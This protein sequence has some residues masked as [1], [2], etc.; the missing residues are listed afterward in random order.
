MVVVVADRADNPIAQGS[1]VA[2][3][4]GRL[5]TNCHVVESA[6]LIT[7]FALGETMRA[8]VVSRDD[9]ADRCVLAVERSVTHSATIRNFD[10][11]KVGER[12]YSIGTPK[13]LALTMAEGIISGLRNEN[14]K[15]Y[16]QTTAP[17]SPG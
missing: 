15:R 3:S 9:A 10:D 5:L 8:R 4:S 7:L 12:V 1:A 2:V 17:I 14:D 6:A 16:I 13:G 11:L